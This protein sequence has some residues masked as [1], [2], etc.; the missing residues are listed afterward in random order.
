M[1]GR[2]GLKAVLKAQ[3][4]LVLMVA[5]LSAL[6]ATSAPAEDRPTDLTI[7]DWVRIALQ[8]DPRVDADD[9]DV[10]TVDGI[11]SLDGT[12]QNLAAKAFADME[13]KKVK[14][15]MGVIDELTVDTPLVYDFDIAHSIL[16]RI[17]NSSSIKNKN[18][19]VDVSHGNVTLTGNVSSWAEAEQAVLLARETTGVLSVTNDM[20]VEYPSH[21]SDSDIEADINASM[22]RDVYLTGL[23]IDASVR[24]GV[25]TLTGHVGTAYQKDRAATDVLWIWNV[26]K[27]D[28]KLDVLWWDNEGTRTSPTPPS[29]YDLQQSVYDELLADP[30]LE[31][32]AITVQASTGHVTLSG[33]V[34]T[35]YQKRVAEGDAKDVVGTAWV[36]NML[37]ATAVERS[38]IAILADVQ[39]ELS[40]DYA[41]DP[42]LVA[43]SVKDGVVTLT[44][45]VEAVWEK[46]HATDVVSRISGVK[47]VVNDIEV[48]PL[49][50]YTDVVI[51]DRVMER[52]ETNAE[53][54]WAAA[55]ITVDVTGGKVTLTGTVNTWAEYYDAEI[56]AFNTS[57]VWAVDNKLH[58]DGYKYDW[59]GFVSPYVFVFGS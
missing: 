30:R 3:G 59:I 17:L 45:E 49:P 53:T 26:K 24:D 28:N 6:C 37:D 33:S 50:Q 29:D 18:I 27:V 20:T 51:R 11:V 38:D 10:S 19:G 44:G 41:L 42:A 58:V 5:S 56:V 39:F 34:P 15:V 36:T 43:A 31:K 14:G 4:M 22:Q 1:F 25:A 48:K 54:R 32:T 8:E 12:V 55:K 21:R 57:G 47:S 46:S 23:P 52:L 2:R 9:I 35:L 13:A 7:S 40:S 16:R